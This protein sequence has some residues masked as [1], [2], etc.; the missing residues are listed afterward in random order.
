MESILIIK[1]T[2]LIENYIGTSSIKIDLSDYWQ[3]KKTIKKFKKNVCQM[4]FNSIK[5]I[6]V[7]IKRCCSSLIQQNV[8]S[9]NALPEKTNPAEELID[10]NSEMKKLKLE[11][12]KSVLAPFHE[13]TEVAQYLKPTFNLAAYVNKSETLQQFINLGVDLSKIEKRKGLGDFVLRLD[14]NKDVKEHLTFLHDVGVPSDELGNFITQN[15]LIFKEDLD[16]LQTRI[17]Y[18]ISKNFREEQITRVIVKNPFWLMFTTQRIDKRLGFFQKNFDLVG[19]EVRSLSASQPKLITYQM[20]HIRKNTFSIKEE[21]GFD[22][23]ETKQ[24]LLTKPRLWMM[25]KLIIF[26]YLT[27]YSNLMF[28]FCFI[29]QESLLQRFDYL[30]KEMNISN[31]KIVQEPECL[32]T[33]EFRLKQRHQF[34]SYLGKAQYDPTKDLYISLKSLVVGT[35]L[36]FVL[37]VAK[38]SI[39]VYDSFLR[40]L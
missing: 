30:N 19:Y 12:Q 27:F 33:R 38:T 7:Y 10:W 6:D 24:L 2:H 1:L 9:K 23:E 36:E 35:D 40:T 25:S 14:F 8:V 32:L 39:D 31:E 18:L 17:N 20:E 37:N 29:D 13:K 26:F 22:D 34:L 21:M 4:M 15:P 5:R 11:E 16:N 28:F 3:N